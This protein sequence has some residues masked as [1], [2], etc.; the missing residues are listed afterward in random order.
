[1]RIKKE[2]NLIKD[3]KYN[4]IQKF[5]NHFIGRSKD[6]YKDDIN[7]KPIF[8]INQFFIH[9]DEKRYQEMKFCL[10]KNV[11]NNH[12]EK[13]YLLNERIYS[14]EELGVKNNKII[15]IDIKKRLTF[16]KAF[17]FARGLEE[18]Y[19]IICNSDIFLD[20]TVKNLQR[21][22]LAKIP[23]LQ[24]L[25]RYEYNEELPLENA[26]IFGPRADSQD[27]WII[28]NTYLKNVEL[29]NMN[30]PMGQGGCDNAITERFYRMGFTIYNEPDMIKTYHY[31]TEEGTRKW[32]NEKKVPMPYY[33]PYPIIDRILKNEKTS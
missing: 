20:Q 32:Y 27:T 21:G 19:C 6:V 14:D 9:K 12:I 5:N 30:F 28:Y 31:H 2:N 18:S 23:S 10:Q 33:Y 24:A 22:S 3:E 11:D 1:M 4:L 16:E 15:Q 29:S 26:K 25:L 7:D 8:M 17:D 13:I